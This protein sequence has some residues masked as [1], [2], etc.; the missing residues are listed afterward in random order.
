M[1]W[2]WSHVG[3]HFHDL[4]TTPSLIRIF[5]SS[6]IAILRSVTLIP[7]FFS[8]TGSRAHVSKLFVCNHVFLSWCEGISECDFSSLVCCLCKCHR[9]CKRIWIHILYSHVV[10]LTALQNDSS[11][12]NK[13]LTTLA[14]LFLLQ[15]CLQKLHR[16]K[17]SLS[18]KMMRFCKLSSWLTALINASNR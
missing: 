9:V 12:R 7:T 6:L 18:T 2:I 5:S 11:T 4:L 3:L 17:K 16:A 1:C 8:L 13:L 10:H 14:I 15:K